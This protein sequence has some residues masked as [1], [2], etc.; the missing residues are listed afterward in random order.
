MAPIATGMRSPQMNGN[1]AST[2]P[3]SPSSAKANRR[4]MPSAGFKPSRMSSA[5]FSGF[6]GSRS[7]G[8]Q[9]LP[10]V[11]DTGVALKRKSMSELGAGVYQTVED[12]SFVNLVSWIR[13]ER[14]TS[15][16]HKGSTWDTVL[17]RALYFADHL[18]GFENAV[19][20]FAS[21]SNAAAQLGYGHTK[22]LLELGH[23]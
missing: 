15:L 18:H 10:I 13:Q 7:Q 1:G 16:P 9:K 5:G 3:M 21:G 6:G 20:G 23:Q 11:E 12:T 14:L 4:S 19:Q 22:L 2:P 17:I 8:S